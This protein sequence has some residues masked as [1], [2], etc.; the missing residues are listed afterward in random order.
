MLLM[1]RGLAMRHKA[2]EKPG[3]IVA[4]DQCHHYW[5][6]EMANGP[7]SKGVCKY[8]GEVRDFM[9]T[10][11]APSSPRRQANPLRLPKMADVKLDKD[12]QS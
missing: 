12:T 6:I 9:N 3:D 2:R 11:P 7:V 5:I 4:R 1:A 8:C 10:M